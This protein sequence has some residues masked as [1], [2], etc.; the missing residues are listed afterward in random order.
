MKTKNKLSYFGILSFLFLTFYVWNFSFTWDF[1]LGVTDFVVG[2]LILLTIGLVLATIIDYQRQIRI[3]R[4]F[5]VPIIQLL[6]IWAISDPVRNWQMES[7]FEKSEIII[8]SLETYKDQF[9]VYPETLS[10]L[11]RKLNRRIPRWT[12][13]GTRYWYEEDKVFGFGLRYQSYYGY[14][15]AYSILSKEWSSQD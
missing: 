3:K 4:Y 1:I 8:E 2:L 6:F 7:T 14:T 15:T 13:L 5:I 10:E 12:N 9:G 11:S